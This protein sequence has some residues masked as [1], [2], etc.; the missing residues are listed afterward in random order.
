MSRFEVSDFDASKVRTEILERS[1]DK[2]MDGADREGRSRIRRVVMGEVL[3]EQDRQE[4]ARDNEFQESRSPSLRARRGSTTPTGL[5]E[6]AHK[7]S[8][9]GSRS[10]RRN[11][12]RQGYSYRQD[13]APYGDTLRPMGMP[14]HDSLYP[15]P[16]AETSHNPVRYEVRSRGRGRPQRRARVH[17]D[18]NI[19]HSPDSYDK[20]YDTDAGPEIAAYGEGPVTGQAYG[21]SE[22]SELARSS[23]SRRSRHARIR[24][25][26]R[27]SDAAAANNYGGA[28][29]ED[30]VARLMSELTTTGHDAAATSQGASP[31]PVVNHTTA[32]DV[33]TRRTDAIGAAETTGEPNPTRGVVEAAPVRTDTLDLTNAEAG[34]SRYRGPTTESVV[35]ADQTT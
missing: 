24:T 2:L 15:P 6:A 16:A 14:A 1:V 21:I 5:R 12:H 10:R 3:A 29:V 35:D 30:E 18:S 4:E 26:R 20:Y 25:D 8:R 28:L 32:G 9:S 17:E 27:A 34:G 7:R 31:P 11:S 22:R 19:Y 33:E 13:S 23:I